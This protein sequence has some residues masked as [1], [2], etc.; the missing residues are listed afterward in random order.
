M[1][2]VIEIYREEIEK[3][4]RTINKLQKEIVDL[5]GRYADLQGK[6]VEA[7]QKRVDTIHISQKD[8][9]EEAE[10]QIQAMKE[11]MENNIKTKQDEMTNYKIKSLT[12]EERE[13]IKEVKEKVKN[14]SSNVKFALATMAGLYDEDMTIDADFSDLVEYG[15]IFPECDEGLT[16][17][18]E[19]D[20]GLY[21]GSI[22]IE[23]TFY[24]KEESKL[25]EARVLEND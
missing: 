6:Y 12:Q 19:I 21:I 15:E 17:V 13:Q 3:A 8:L 5:Q 22:D 7:L 1:N 2:N 14:L 16:I 23:F 20:L 9:K 25:K 18:R 24:N 4:Y 10:K 11:K